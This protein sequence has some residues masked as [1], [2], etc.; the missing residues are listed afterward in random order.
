MCSKY[1]GASRPGRQVVSMSQVIVFLF[2]WLACVTVDQAD[3]N[4]STSDWTVQTPTPRFNWPARTWSAA[5]PPIVG[6]IQSDPF[7]FTITPGNCQATIIYADLDDNG[8]IGGITAPLTAPNDC[9]WPHQPIVNTDID[10]ANISISADGHTLY[11]NA[12]AVDN[13]C[14]GGDHTGWANV[15]IQWKARCGCSSCAGGG[16][17]TA[18]NNCVRV[19]LGLG[20][21]NYQQSAGQLLVQSDVPNALLATPAGLQ[22]F[23]APTDIRVNDAS[24][25]VR[26]VHTSQLLAD[27]VLSNRYCYTV[28]FYT[29]SNVS[30]A[31]VNGLYV[32]TGPAFS[33]I[34]VQN[35]DASSGIY[36]RLFVTQTG[37]FGN[38]EYD[39]V[40]NTASQS[41][42]LTSGDGLRTEA[43]LS[44]WD[45]TG[46]FLTETNIVSN[47]DGSVASKQVETFEYF[48]WGQT[49]LIQ[50]VVDPDGPWP[51]TNTWV[52]SEDMFDGSYQQ[53]IS[54]TQP[55]GYWERYEYDG[56]GHVIKQVAQFG[57]ALI[58]ASDTQCHVTTNAYDI[59]ADGSGSLLITETVSVELLLGQEIKRCYSLA[60]P[61]GISNFVCQTAGASIDATDNLAGVSLQFTNGPF[62]FE[63][64]FTQNPDGTIITYQYSTNALSQTTITFTGAPDATGTNVIDGTENISVIDLAGNSISNATY[65][66]ASGLLLSSTTTLQ[67]DEFGRPTLLKYNDGST[68]E[69]IYGCCGLESKTDREGI[70]TSY[71]YDA[72]KRVS[73][74]T[75]AGITTIY[76]YDAAGRTLTT[77]RQGTDNSQIL[78]N[79]S[80]YDLASKLIATTNALNYGTLYS[81]VLDGNG[82]TIKMTI[83]PDGGTRIETDFQDGTQQ[84]VTGTAVQGVRSEYGVEIPTGENIY[85]A[86]TKQIKLNSDGSDSQEWTKTYNDMVGRTYKTTSAGTTTHPSSRSIFNNVGQL[87]KQIDQ[88]G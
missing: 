14:Q 49:N 63:N 69:T 81:Q 50:R 65:D 44:G 70:T 2:A 33:I 35:P 29:S 68:G 47:T 26:Q 15:Q 1:W 18:A 71:I 80:V 87:I 75:R 25:M 17:C 43:R 4:S 31:T 79:T 13:L 85:R 64:F 34:T 74:A 59:L 21:D 55:S 77:T 38:H 16:N 67:T 30:P 46:T 23:L 88:M 36:N 58:T 5:N 52:Y 57:D 76:T 12:F 6:T 60:F 62:M 9:G 51:Q 11:V 53:L 56:A 83:H 20:N 45:A 28:S 37:D 40:W 27:I 72:L 54:M 39:Y 61:G 19:S 42:T 3:A 86:Y 73:S 41:W 32:P 78:Q 84:S 82:H 48:P 24:G 10:P 8:S 7:P 66:V 22:T